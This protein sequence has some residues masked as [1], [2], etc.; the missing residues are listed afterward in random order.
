MPEPL[1]NVLTT[2]I[3]AA[4]D[5]LS[6][7]VYN[8]I[9]VIAAGVFCGLVVDAVLILAEQAYYIVKAYRDTVNPT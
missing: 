3:S 8:P 4:G 6:E 5:M 1:P 9:K 7:C 2:P